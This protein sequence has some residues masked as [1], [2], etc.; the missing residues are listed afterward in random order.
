MWRNS[1]LQ[2]DITAND[3]DDNL[4]TFS[5]AP[6]D[7][8]WATLSDHG[9]GTATLTLSPGTTDIGVHDLTVTV[10]DGIHEDA[11]TFSVDVITGIALRGSAAAATTA[12]PAAWSWPS[13]QAR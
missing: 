12:W 1:T 10:S 13:R 2:V 5:L 11:E 3:A 8:D 4:L 7:H 6:G 9:D